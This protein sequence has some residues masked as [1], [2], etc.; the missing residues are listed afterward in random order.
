MAQRLGK[1]RQCEVRYRR[2]SPIHFYVTADG[3]LI[4]LQSLGEL[5]FY[6][7]LPFA[8]G[9]A[10]PKSRQTRLKIAEKLCMTYMEKLQDF[11]DDVREIAN[12]LGGEPNS[13]F[14]HVG[15]ATH[16]KKRLREF[17]KFLIFYW[18]GRIGSNQFAE[19]AHTILELLL[20]NVTQKN[21]NY[22]FAQL[23]DAAVECGVVSNDYRTALIE[24]KDLRKGAKHHGKEI[25]VDK[26]DEMVP[27]V[28][29][30]CQILVSA[31]RRGY[32]ANNRVEVT[33]GPAGAGPS[34]AHTE[35]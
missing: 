20:K 16:L 5:L 19:E 17:T 26:M 11:S 31:I 21:R 24:L 33:S 28:L 4:S 3:P 30:A 6:N 23:V 32:Q 2:Q 12:Q 29:S 1:A 27:K 7:L 15:G 9:F 34:A 13:F 8:E 25:S 18:E 10:N 22:S 35:R 14:F